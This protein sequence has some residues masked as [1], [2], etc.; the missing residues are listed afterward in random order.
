MN[1][2]AGK[3]YTMIRNVRGTDERAFEV[4]VNWVED[5]GD[6]WYIGYEP[7]IH[8]ICMWGC[9]KV[10]KHGQYKTVNYRFQAA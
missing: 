6:F 4:T 10:K 9:C 7:V 3:R 2:E 8:R 1:I 5:R